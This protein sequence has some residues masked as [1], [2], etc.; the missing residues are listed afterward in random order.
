MIRGSCQARRS[1]AT[2]WSRWSAL[3]RLRR[4][5]ARTAP[6]CAPTS[7]LSTRSSA[8]TRSCDRSWAR[9]ASC[10]GAQGSSS[11]TRPRSSGSVPTAALRVKAHSWP[12]L[13]A[14]DRLRLREGPRA[15]APGSAI[16][17]GGRLLGEGYELGS[18]RLRSWYG[19]SYAWK[20]ATSNREIA[21][22][23]PPGD[24]C[25]NEAGRGRTRLDGSAPPHSHDE[26]DPARR[27]THPEHVHRDQRRPVG[28][29]RKAGVEQ[30]GEA[31][32]RH[33]RGL[34][35]G[36]GGGAANRVTAS[37]SASRS[38]SCRP[39]PRTSV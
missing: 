38:P 37:A 2:A 18:A 28:A 21:G 16:V 32:G 26:A 24:A 22:R 25:A 8:S 3:H 39:R 7:E 34:L 19:A 12:T 31:R 23:S 27:A 20:S 10:A 33:G 13:R 36:G 30:A 29:G 5:R 15:A 17:R 4:H 14:P 9:R 11:R 6:S 35:G 1:R